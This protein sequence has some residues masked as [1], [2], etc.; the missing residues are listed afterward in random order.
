MFILHSENVIVNP[1]WICPTCITP[2]PKRAPL[3]RS[4][5]PAVIGLRRAEKAAPREGRKPPRGKKAADQR[6]PKKAK[7]KRER[8]TLTLCYNDFSRNQLTLWA[9]PPSP[10]SPFSTSRLPTAHCDLFVGVSPFA[11]QKVPLRVLRVNLLYSHMV[12]VRVVCS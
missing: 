2:I 1:S 7:R 10:P 8:P 6:H 4:V 11:Y 5:A 9:H 3:W 12:L